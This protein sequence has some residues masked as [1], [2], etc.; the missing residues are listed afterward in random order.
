LLFKRRIDIGGVNNNFKRDFQEAEGL[1][2]DYDLE[3]GRK[4]LLIGG[5]IGP[6]NNRHHSIYSIGQRGVNQFL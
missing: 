6:G 3:T 4:A 2:M 5:T 1:D